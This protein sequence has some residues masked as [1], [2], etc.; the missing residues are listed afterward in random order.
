[1]HATSTAPTYSSAE[2][3][4]FSGTRSYFAR[5]RMTPMPRQTSP[6]LCS[7]RL[8][9]QRH[10][11]ALGFHRVQDI[12]IA[13]KLTVDEHLGESRPVRQP[14]QRFTLGRLRQHV[15]D[16]IGIAILLK[17]MHGFPR[18]PTHR[19]GL[20][21]LADRKSTRLNSSHQKISYAVFCLK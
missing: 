8:L 21:P 6:L 16:F 12:R 7:E 4:E 10:H 20:R 17:K 1:M 19:H 18:K 9:Q 13:V 5:K 14:G 3:G 15:D 2:G 11:F